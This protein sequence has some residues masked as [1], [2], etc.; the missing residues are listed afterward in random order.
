MVLF[1]CPFQKLESL[2]DFVY[3]LLNLR[4]VLGF[5]ES[6]WILTMNVI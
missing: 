2:L 3:A 1:Q 4:F 6:F 5:V